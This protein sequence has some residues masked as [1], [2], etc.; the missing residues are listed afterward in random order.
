MRV[1]Y[2]ITLPVEQGNQTLANGSLMTK[3]QA[4]LGE[5]K[6]EAAYFGV[7]GGQRGAYIVCDL[8]DPSG[9]PGAVEPFFMAFNADVEICPV[10]TAEDLAKS[11]PAIERAAKQYL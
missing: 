10:M 5:L 6:P 3:L 1:M 2:K 4:I 11:G 9:I 7:I 8:A